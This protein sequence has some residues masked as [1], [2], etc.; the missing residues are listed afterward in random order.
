MLKD[1]LYQLNNIKI[2]SKTLIGKNL[3]ISESLVEDA[4]NQLIRMGY[5]VDNIQSLSCEHTC[6]GCSSS[7]CN[8]PMKTL[9]ITDKGKKLLKI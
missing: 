6:S 8:E 1:V 2:F 3:N 4:I 9:S 7:S 5:V